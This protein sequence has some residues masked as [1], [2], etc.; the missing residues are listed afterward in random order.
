MP[1][2]VAD[3]PAAFKAK[4]ATGESVPER[5]YISIRE[6][7]KMSAGTIQSLR[8]P[9]LIRSGT[10]TVGELRPIRRVERI[11]LHVI[12]ASRRR[13]E[14]LN[15]MLSPEDSQQMAEARKVLGFPDEDNAQ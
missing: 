11:P 3:Q 10:A 5:D 4:P 8:R 12:E 6:L 15:A 9:V 2:R 7:Q 14:T 13:I 1:N